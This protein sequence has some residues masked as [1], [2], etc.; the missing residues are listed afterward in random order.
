M[1]ESPNPEIFLALAAVGLAL[2]AAYFR[3]QWLGWWERPLA[4][5]ARKRGLAILVAALLPLAVRALLLIRFP[6]PEP[7][8][9]DEFTFLL[10]ADTFAHGRLAN[11][12][13]PLW[14]HFE[15]FHMLMR[16]TYSSAF[17]IAPAAF[18]AFGEVFFGQPWI[19]VW[20]GAA[21]LCGSVCWM[22][23]GSVSPRWAFVGTV[24]LILRLA[25][26]SYWMNSYWGG[27]V[28]AGGGALVLGSVLRSRRT[29]R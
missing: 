5:V 1:A 3:W 25:V 24:L 13:H 19:G 8:V 12:Q 23:Q 20:M 2:V 21:F 28:A 26:S 7:R 11:P 18:L 17:P 16:P 29:P 15:S 27:F 10:A 22:L 4:A 9:H 14:P 6:A